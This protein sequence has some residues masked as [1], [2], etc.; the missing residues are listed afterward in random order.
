MWR[1]GS[2][3]WP[4]AA[5]AQAI[6]GDLASALHRP[7]IA[8]VLSGAGILL[9]LIEFHR[10]GRI[11]P[12]AIGLGLVLLGAHA[13]SLQ[14]ARVWAVV[15]LLCALVLLG[16][17]WLLPQRPEMGA[18]G[19]AALSTALVFLPRSPGTGWVWLAT[20]AGVLLGAICSVLTTV[21]GRARRAKR[22]LDPGATAAEHWE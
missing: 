6:P 3:P 5:L 14:P 16:S 15:L 17:P 2:V 4:A 11:L 9:I 1:L 22:R 20:S 8:L 18:L 12:G 10:P 7:A 21:A 13:F 19:T